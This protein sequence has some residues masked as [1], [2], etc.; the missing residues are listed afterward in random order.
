MITWSSQAEAAPPAIR[1]PWHR[2]LTG[3]ERAMLEAALP[4]HLPGQRWFGGKAR[5]VASVRIRD[6]LPLGS[7]D[8]SGRL[9]LVDVA[10][11]DGALETYVLPLAWSE[12]EAGATTVALLRV[13]GQQ[14]V[15]RAAEYDSAFAE[16][17]LADIAAGRKRRGIQGVLSARATKLFEEHAA[18][19]RRLAATVLSGEQ[20]NTSIRF[21][22]RLLLKL[23]RKIVPG[24]NSEL[25]IGEYLTLDVGFPHVPPVLGSVV[26]EP[27]AGEPFVVALLQG[28]ARNRG[29]LWGVAV[30]A[31]RSCAEGSP[32]RG[33]STLRRPYALRRHGPPNSRGNTYADIAALL[34]RR[35]AELHSA[36][37]ARTD[38]P[39]FCPEPFTL[40]RQKVLHASVLRQAEA[41]FAVLEQQLGRFSRVDQ[42]LGAA[43]LA[44]RA[45]IPRRI[46]WLCERRIE[47][48]RIRTHGDYHLGQV[49]WTGSDVVI[50]DFEGEPGRSNSERREK[51]SALRDVA[52]MLRSFHYAARTGGAERLASTDRPGFGSCLRRGIRQASGAF[53]NAYL[54][55]V[56]GAPFLPK[57]ELDL[58]NLLQFHLLEKALYELH[59]ELN[60]RPDWVS[61]PLA[62]LAELLGVA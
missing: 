26:Y 55:T 50:I 16:T 51:Q 14:G 61:L 29:E 27:K 6:A 34:G 41:S 40:E 21:G 60:N 10:F 23:Y 56:A 4:S 31:A 25:E 28:F 47:A 24:V 43:I 53:M 3:P 59:Y 58:H 22:E 7:L 11:V 48:A 5:T 30:A 39:A 42:A 35:T 9:A 37:A 44:G 62:G 2:I 57:A 19:A 8:E 49:L 13:D 38:H 18:G 36:L 33:R 20:S 52:G 12:T 1:G 15:L 54:R 17:I 32:S 46:G 45:R